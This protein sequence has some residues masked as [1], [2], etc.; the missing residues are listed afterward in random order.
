MCAVWSLAQAPANLLAG[1]WQLPQNGISVQFDGTGNYEVTYANG[2]TLKN[3]YSL[4]G[5]QLT[6]SAF[7]YGQDQRFRIV[8]LDAQQLVLE[9][10]DGQPGMQF[11][12]SRITQA[13]TPSVGFGGFSSN[14]NVSMSSASAT[15]QQQVLAERNGY[16]LT[17]G[18]FDKVVRFAE[19]IIADR[20]SEEEWAQAL[21]ECIAE[22]EQSPQLFLQSVAMLDQQMQQFYQIEDLLQ[23]ALVRS[24]I[25]GQLDLSYKQVPY[26]QKPYLGKLIDKYTRVLA[27]DPTAQLALTWRDVEGYAGVWA[28]YMEVAGQ[29]VQL[30]QQE[31][32]ALSQQLVQ[33]FQISTPEQKALLC[34]MSLYDDFLRA[35]WAQL[36]PDQQAQMRSQMMQQLVA[37]AGNA[38]GDQSMGQQYN[39]GAS[40]SGMGG[41]KADAQ[42]YLEQ[43]RQRMAMNDMTFNMMQN[44]MMQQH[45]ASLNVIENIGTPDTYWEVKYNDW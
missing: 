4:I 25:V 41:S 36:T 35:A 44:M 38:T 9:A 11:A 6:L 28:F 40:P 10:I 43:M 29:P 2:Q 31:L 27:Y 21:A 45:A 3:T 23:L 15:G 32:E 30:T 18:D 33:Q 1:T 19:F 12:F 14:S 8:Q 7:F 16:T 24:M 26:E 39:Y 20:L 5:D 42:L 37:Y 34:A 17:K 13:G 22:F